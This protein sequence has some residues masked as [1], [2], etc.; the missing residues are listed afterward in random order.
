MDIGIPALIMEAARKIDEWN[1]I[2]KVIPSL[3]IVLEIEPNP[4]TDVEEINLTANEWRVL[5][6]VDGEK[7][8][9]QIARAL[10]IGEIET[11]KIVFGLL[12]SGLIRIKTAKESAP[13]VTEKKAE[14]PEKE[15]KKEEE[16]KGKG[17]FDFFK[18]K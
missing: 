17:F 3:D 1:R 13:K 4:D 7:S 16:K 2:K 6:Q 9:K 18:K 12:G 15:E 10:K 5:S 14:E 8:I 11:A